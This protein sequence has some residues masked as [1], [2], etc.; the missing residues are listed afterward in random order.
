MALDSSV[1]RGGDTRRVARLRVATEYRS[2]ILT[3]KPLS[4]PGVLDGSLRPDRSASFARQ[5]V[6]NL[7]R[8]RAMWESRRHE[9]AASKPGGA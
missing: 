6:R 7:A 3:G 2:S 4:R 9:A 1:V 5:K 8:A